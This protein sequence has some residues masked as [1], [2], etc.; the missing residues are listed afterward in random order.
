MTSTILSIVVAGDSHVM[1]LKQQNFDI[2]ID[3]PPRRFTAM[4][5]P[6]FMGGGYV[7]L[8]SVVTFPDGRLGLNPLLD[9]GLSTW[10]GLTVKGRPQID[11]TTVHKHL[12]L[13]LG[14]A[15]SSYDPAIDYG[16]RGAERYLFKHDVDFIL[17]THADLPIDPACALLPVALVRDMY[18]GIL[19]PLRQALDFLSGDFPGRIWILGCP[20]PSETN[21]VKEKT[22]ARRTQAV[23][24]PP[25]PLPS[26]TVSLKLWLLV[27]QCVRA[28]CTETRV[29]FI[30][31]TPVACDPRGFLRPEFVADGVH[32]NA[33]YNER[34]AQHV[35][36]VLA[37]AEI[38]SPR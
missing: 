32:G 27:N 8:D 38:N 25:V 6:V 1:G 22:F 9:M 31:C 24:A 20:P 34:L 33:R 36:T 37:T 7:A 17:P 10:P 26:P 13:S 15:V 30:D 5:L 28:I 16:D 14:T 2:S 11:G 3:Q 12:V 29:R 4:M 19:Q 23:G 35:V 18:T 21:E